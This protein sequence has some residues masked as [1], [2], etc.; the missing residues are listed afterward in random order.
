MGQAFSPRWGI[1]ISTA[2][3]CLEYFIRRVPQGFQ[4][5]SAN[6]YRK[7]WHNPAAEL[8]ELA[9][10][11]GK[12]NLQS[13]VKVISIDTSIWPRVTILGVQWFHSS[14]RR[15]LCLWRKALLRNGVAVIRIRMWVRWA[16]MVDG[17]NSEWTCSFPAHTKIIPSKAF[18]SNHRMLY[19][20]KVL[21]LRGCPSFPII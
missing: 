3:S 4:P 14:G 6:F 11:H 5:K 1:F 18:D 8:A 16:R 17:T 2:H 13:F 12:K 20:R 15:H 7:S 19:S 9:A 21:R 10:V